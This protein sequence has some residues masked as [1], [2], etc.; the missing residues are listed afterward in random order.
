MLATLLQSNLANPESTSGA[1]PVFE[2]SAAPFHPCASKHGTTAR[3]TEHSWMDGYSI[4]EE[5]TCMPHTADSD[6]RFELTLRLRVCGYL[7]RFMLRTNGFD[8]IPY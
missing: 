7:A 5:P 6:V 4:F 3:K 1:P 8:A 2:E